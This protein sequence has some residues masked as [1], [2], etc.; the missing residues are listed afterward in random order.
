MT[1]VVNQRRLRVGK[2]RFREI[3]IEVRDETLRYLEKQ[4]WLGKDKQPPLF[5]TTWDINCGDCETF[6]VDV[7]MRVSGAQAVWLDELNAV[8]LEEEWIAHCVVFYKDR[9]YDAEC[10]DGV[11][12]WEDIPLVKNHRRQATRE[13][14][15]NERGGDR[16]WTQ[17]PSGTP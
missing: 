5:P 7:C 12:K 11:D 16:L 13:Q 4:G 6:A 15:M 14:V 3:L 2:A 17:P 9:Y 1:L 8:P 10:I